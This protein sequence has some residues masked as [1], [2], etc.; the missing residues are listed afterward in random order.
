MKILLP[1]LALNILAGCEKPNPMITLPP[2]YTTVVSA[3]YKDVSAFHETAYIAPGYDAL[4]SEQAFDAAHDVIIRHLNKVGKATEETSGG[5]FYLNRYFEPD[6]YITVV[7]DLHA[8]EVIIA[9]IAAQKE[10]KGEFAI[11]LDSYPASVYVIPDGR[12]IGYM[13]IHDQEDRDEGLKILS[14]YGLQIETV[15][16][17]SSQE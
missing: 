14:D 16:E 6:G 12:V 3:D 4:P 11:Q 17:S 10:L 15:A 2:N 9:L 13:D 7:S 8:P 1:I 5:D